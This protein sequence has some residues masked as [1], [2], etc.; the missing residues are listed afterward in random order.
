[1]NSQWLT[2][3]L[4]CICVT[5]VSSLEAHAIVNINGNLVEHFGVHIQTSHLGVGAYRI[6]FR[7]VN[8]FDKETGLTSTLGKPFVQV[9]IVARTHNYTGNQH[10]MLVL[11][12]N[13]C[14]VYLHDIFLY[15]V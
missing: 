15:Y 6:D 14:M 2:I 9:T 7:H 4:T 5:T 1:M 11:C 10:N 8:R 13:Y 12:L 3:A